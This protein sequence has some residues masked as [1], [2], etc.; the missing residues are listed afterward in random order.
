MRKLL[1]IISIL[2]AMVSCST[3]TAKEDKMNIIIVMA[4]QY[5]GNAFGFLGK[6]AV[7]T[8]NFD[9]F[10]RSAVVLNQATSSYPVSSPARGMFMSGAYPHVNNVLVNCN[11][12]SAH[13]DIELRADLVCWSDILA[14]QGYATSYYGKWHLDKP[15]EPYI[16]CGNNKGDCK[17]NEWCPPERR[18]SFQ[19]WVAYGTYDNHLR[20][21]YW[22][23]DSKREEFYYVDKWGPEYEVDLAIAAIDSAS[24]EQ[25]PFAI[26]VSM[27]PPHTGY[28]Y[29]PDKY[30]ELYRDLNVDSIALSIAQLQSSKPGNIE[31][32]KRSV[33]D[34][35]ACISGVDEQFGRILQKLED[36]GA[37]DN[38]IIIFTSDH[39][40]SMGMHD[41][42]GKNVIY[43]EAMRIPF[44]I[45]SPK[46][47]GRIDN[48][49]LFSLEDFYP[50][51]LS[52]MGYEDLLPKSV[53]TRN[54]SNQI[55]GSRDDMPTSQLYMKY[56]AVNESGKNLDT[57]SRGIRGERYSY[58]V[59]FDKGV[60][61]KEELYDRELDPSQ[62]VNIAYDNREIRN[63]LREELYNRLSEIEDPIATVMS[64]Y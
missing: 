54:L 23:R 28:S 13:Q 32:F 53:K 44:L 17:W 62:L 15:Y 61:E 11:S 35:Y 42:I 36:E 21:L 34:Y 46:I 12:N 2:P 24:Q 8:P 5:R 47:K 19:N 10:S 9:R 52:H 25:K 51:I 55:E 63:L 49:L 33:A 64:G 14:S 6:E 56:G 45:Y 59:H 57:G 38:T 31:M 48:E 4:D 3:T 20:P 39:G 22:N 7:K 43:E 1:P 40:D 60:V 37:M 26:M 16:D 41:N 30:K 50:S 27:N 58:V 29:V 18:H